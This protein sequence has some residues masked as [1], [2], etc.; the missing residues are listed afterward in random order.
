MAD[1]YRRNNYDDYGDNYGSSSRRRREYDSDEEYPVTSRYAPYFN[2]YGDSSESEDAMEYE[3]IYSDS[4]HPRNRN[5]SESHRN[6][7][8]SHSRKRRKKKG[9][10]GRF[11]TALLLVFVLV[12]GV[13]F[14][15]LYIVLEPVNYAPID[16]SDDFLSWGSEECV[17]ELYSSNRV[18]NIMLFGV[19]EDTSEYGRSDTMLL[20]S[21]DKK[22]K[23]LKMTSFQRDTFVYVPDPEGDY[24]TKLTN[25]FSYGGVP[26]AINTIEANYGVKIDHYVTVNFETFK[27]IVDVLGGVQLELTDREILYI[28]CQIAQNNQTEYLDAEEGLV[29][30][31][32]QQALWYARNRGGDIINGVEFYEGTDWDRTERQR[33]FLT[34]VIDDVKNANAGELYAIVNEVAPYISTDF[35]KSELMLLIV[36][37]L[38]YLSFDIEQCSMPSDGNWGYEENFAGSVIYVYDWETT[39]SDL[40]SLI[41][42]K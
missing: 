10:F 35:T 25:A 21:I 38:R 15:A 11:L 39:R 9:C 32:G 31:N 13:V 22:H 27:R 14:A 41:Y 40:K 1:D 2:N 42:E 6:R 16:N 37:S 3:E 7:E 8:E 33:K 20:L 18:I 30:L 12:T 17:D 29:T 23:K 34:A 36:N 28:N 5:H 4:H 26:L 24:H 19:D